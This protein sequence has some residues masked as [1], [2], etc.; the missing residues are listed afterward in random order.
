MEVK[1][2]LGISRL[3]TPQQ[4]VLLIYRYIITDAAIFQSYFARI[5][6]KDVFF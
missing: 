2:C 3:K 6:L 1:I 4:S 5:T